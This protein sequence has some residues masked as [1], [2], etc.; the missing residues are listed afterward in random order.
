MLRRILFIA[1][2]FGLTTQPSL[3]IHL[4]TFLT[5]C[6]IMFLGIIRPHHISF[7][8]SVELANETIFVLVCYNFI[9]FTDITSDRELRYS[10]GWCLVALVMLIMAAN[11]SVIFGA[12]AKALLRK[13]KLQKERNEFQLAKRGIYIN[14]M[15]LVLNSQLPLSQRIVLA[16]SAT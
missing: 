11:F 6:Y 9:L 2:T 7:T 5:L 8:T 4:F 13:Y 10:L 3:Q 15:K 16:Q 12:S 1:L 14:K